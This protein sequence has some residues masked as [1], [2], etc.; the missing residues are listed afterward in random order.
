MSGER[1]HLQ[2]LLDQ[3]LD[4]AGSPEAATRFAGWRYTENGQVLPV[5]EGLWATTD[6]IGPYC[7]TFLD[8]DAGQAACFA[9]LTEGRTRS[10]MALRVAEGEIEALVARPAPFGTGGAFGDGPAAL[11]ASTLDPR[12]LAEIDP[13]ERASRDAL[14][15]IADAYFTGLE[16]NDGKGHYPFADDCIRIENGFRTTGV[17]PSPSAGKTPYLEAFRAMSA[18]EQFETG[19]FAFV[20]RIRDRRFPVVDVERG[21]VFSF[22]FFDHSGTIREY[23]LADCT[24]VSAGLDRPFSWMIAEA[25]RIEQG[26]LTRI[27]ALM[28][29]CPYGMKPGWS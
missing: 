2:A 1:G 20:D 5:G 6:R 14:V 3:V 7:H 12:W 15:A 8:P 16:C 19:Y 23:E 22:A 13:T 18:K 10:I 9:T 11:D 26:L 29:E 21:L 4:L 27:E 28:T 17:Q 25:F 24:P